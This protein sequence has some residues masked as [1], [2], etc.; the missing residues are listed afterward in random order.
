MALWLPRWQQIILFLS[1]LIFTY[2]RCIFFNFQ[3]KKLLKSYKTGESKVFLL[4]DGRIRTR[5]AQKA[6]TYGSGSR[7]LVMILKSLIRKHGLRIPKALVICKPIVCKKR[8]K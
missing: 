8:N 2:R 6:K 4:A 3:N 5:E 7:T 1:F